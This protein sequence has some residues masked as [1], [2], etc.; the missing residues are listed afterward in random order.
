MLGLLVLFPFHGLCH[1]PQHP[2]QTSAA[3]L[4]HTFESEPIAPVSLSE[5]PPLPTGAR[6]DVETR[7]LVGGSSVGLGGK[8][9][10]SAAALARWLRSHRALVEGAH[11][12]ELGCG[13]GAVGL[14]AAALGA[15]SVTLTDGG[16]ERLLRVAMANLEAN[17]AHIDPTGCHVRILRHEWGTGQLSASLPPR[18]HL[19]VG[20]DV[21]YARQTHAQLCTSIRS[22]LDECGQPRVVLAHE[23]RRIR[24]VAGG[25]VADR[26]DRGAWDE[27]LE[28][29]HEE[30]ARARLQVSTLGLEHQAKHGLRDIALLE[31]TSGDTVA[32]PD[33]NAICDES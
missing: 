11:V 13:T 32:A 20:S 5:L 25:G 9:W 29:F 18:V 26:A 24:L 12:V 28:H 1:L 23:H 7:G 10:P 27:G 15:A 30:A 3:S 21:T 8:L 33:G 31:V 6:L 14:Y 17:R 19:L 2:S 4:I 22:V 16:D